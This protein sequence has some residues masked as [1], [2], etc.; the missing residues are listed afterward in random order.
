MSV[1]CQ[2]NSKKS[3]TARTSV[4]RVVVLKPKD[5]LPTSFETRASK[6]AE[7]DPIQ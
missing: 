2:Y 5:G 7:K 4:V 6:G 3:E 1:S